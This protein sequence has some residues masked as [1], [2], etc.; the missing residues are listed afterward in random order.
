MTGLLARNGS[1]VGLGILVLAAVAGTGAYAAASGKRGSGVITVC[2]RHDEGGLYRANQCEPND[3]QLS[4]NARGPGGRRGPKGS[5]GTRGRKGDKGAPGTP[6]TPGAPG[7]SG[8]P[9]TP[10]AA[11]IPGAAGTP[12][13]PGAPGPRGPSDAYNAETGGGSPITLTD[14]G[15]FVTVNTVSVP[16]GSVLVLAK[17][18]VLNT[19]GSAAEVFC[20]YPG[21]SDE[22][23]A[24][25]PAA[26]GFGAGVGEITLQHAETLASPETLSVQCE[27]F[28]STVVTS[29]DKLTAIQ[30]GALH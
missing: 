7:T 5:P 10:G 13:A 20:D 27:S 9:G 11:G 15:G 14:R 19:G 28:G 6:G 21:E 16:A 30:L 2:V 3:T 22:N 18:Q 24:I 23:S 12:G 8:P 1:R 29:F 17:M 25:V 26:G 4:W